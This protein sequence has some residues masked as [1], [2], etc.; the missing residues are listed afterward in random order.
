M[1][2]AQ[3]LVRLLQR[4]GMDDHHQERPCNAIYRIAGRGATEQ[5]GGLR[6]SLPRPIQDT[7]HTADGC[8]GKSASI[9]A[10]ASSSSTQQSVN[11]A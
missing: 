7:G 6:Y 1:N 10:R 11:A 9:S 2:G 5:A 4:W 3:W 8:F